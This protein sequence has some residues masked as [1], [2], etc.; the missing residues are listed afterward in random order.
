MFNSTVES[1]FT[2]EALEQTKG[3]RA[4]RSRGYRHC[5]D[6]VHGVLLDGKWL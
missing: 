5:G 2:F 6:V 3:G 1:E 4:C